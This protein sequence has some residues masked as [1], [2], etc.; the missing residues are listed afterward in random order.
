MDFEKRAVFNEK[1]KSISSLGKYIGNAIY[2][3]YIAG[4]KNSMLYR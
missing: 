4:R 3:W 2:K 1:M